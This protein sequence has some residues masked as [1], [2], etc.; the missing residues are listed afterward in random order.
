MSPTPHELA[1]QDEIMLVGV[2]T[3]SLPDLSTLDAI[4]DGA[5]IDTSPTQTTKADLNRSQAEL[6][7]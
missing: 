1:D 6:T 3:D 5:L 7:L 4:L 2:G